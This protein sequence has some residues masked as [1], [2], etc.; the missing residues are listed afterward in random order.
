MGGGETNNIVMGQNEEE[1]N[2]KT[3]GNRQKGDER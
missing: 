1:V 3:E 2:P